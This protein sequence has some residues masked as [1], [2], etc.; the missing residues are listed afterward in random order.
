MGIF[1]YRIDLIYSIFVSNSLFD[2]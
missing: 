2:D 1:R